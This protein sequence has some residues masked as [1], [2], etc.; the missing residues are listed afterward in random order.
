MS[1][2]LT[3]KQAMEQ[4]VR[5][6]IMDALGLTLEEAAE[7]ANAMQSDNRGIELLVRTL[8]HMEASAVLDCRELFEQHAI[9][10]AQGEAK[11]YALILD[12]PKKIRSLISSYI[13]E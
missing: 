1:E 8:K 7:L 2:P 10:R 4:V 3:E 11:A 12:V 13:S 6:K 9:Y 5:D